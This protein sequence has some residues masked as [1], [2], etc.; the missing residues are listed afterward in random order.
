MLPVLER[1]PC[2]KLVLTL[3][4]CVPRPE[5][6]SAKLTFAPLKPVV[7]MFAMLLPIVSRPVVKLSRALT[8]EVRVPRSDI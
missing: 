1:A 3:D 6:V 8:L 2:A 5:K 4:T 7:L